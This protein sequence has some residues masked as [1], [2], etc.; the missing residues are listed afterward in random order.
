[1]FWKSKSF[2]SKNTLGVIKRDIFDVL[3]VLNKNS[4]NYIAENL[5]K[6]IGANNKLY[7]DNYFGAQD[8]TYT[9][10]KKQNIPTKGI[11]INDGSG[12]S[13]RNLLTTE[14]LLR[15]LE[16]V[17]KKNYGEKFIKCL[18]VAGE[19]GTLR[20]RMKNTAAEDIL[21]G[22]TGTLRNVSALAG[23]TTTLD[24]EKLAYSFIFN[25]NSVSKYKS[26]ENELGELISQFFYFNEE[27]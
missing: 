16:N 18:A 1:M 23:V 11:Y 5:F 6:I 7:D 13:R 22:K 2:N 4:D 3:E 9:I 8:L 26:I 14:T 27:H 10:L 24:G 15:I 21:I 25:G 12:L 20:K 19:D 17:S